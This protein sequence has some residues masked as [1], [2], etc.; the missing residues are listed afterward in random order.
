MHH[1]RG[2]CRHSSPV[3]AVASAPLRALNDAAP[4]A[5]VSRPA[6]C[7]SSWPHLQSWPRPSVWGGVP[8]PLG[9]FLSEKTFSPNRKV[10]GRGC[11]TPATPRG[12]GP[13][14]LCQGR[15]WLR[16]RILSPKAVTTRAARS[17]TFGIVARRPSAGRIAIRFDMPDV[18]F[19]TATHY[20]HPPPPG[21]RWLDRACLEIR[22]YV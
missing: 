21:S 15:H 14:P 9:V 7:L 12:G 5:E 1:T 22:G 18:V 20:T 17:V 2:P 6:P 3:R 13:Q 8:P 19:V 10:A 4:A 16:R 11:G